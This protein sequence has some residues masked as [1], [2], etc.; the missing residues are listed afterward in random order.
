[1]EVDSFLAAQ[2]VGSWPL[3]RGPRKRHVRE[4]LFVDACWDV[5]CL[6]LEI[7]WDQFVMRLADYRVLASASLDPEGCHI[8]DLS[9]NAH[10]AK[11]THQRMFCLL[12]NS[13]PFLL[14]EDLVFFVACSCITY[15]KHMMCDCSGCF[16][17]YLGQRPLAN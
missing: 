4:I 8:A 12:R 6:G 3:S 13:K 10:F 17:F 5:M 15:S 2:G 11:K 9:Q 7:C 14:G 16:F 1:M